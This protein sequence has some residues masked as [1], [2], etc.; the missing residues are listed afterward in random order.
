MSEVDEI[1]CICHES[2]S[3]GKQ[4]YKLPECDHNFHI[5]CISAWWIAPRDRNDE[6]GNCPLCRGVPLRGIWK[7]FT[8]A[9][10]ISQL[11]R[12]VKKNKV[13]KEVIKAL[14]KLQKA[15]NKLKN[16][17]QEW[18]EFAKR[19]DVKNICK[20]ITK[21]RNNRW[22]YSQQVHKYKLELAAF[23]PMA[24]INLI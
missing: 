2:L 12:L 14:H 4:T 19:P 17:R 13:P 11:K 15:E 10:R 6:P 18:R 24:F 1:C 8:V 20:Q 22:K 5:A 9:G 16:Q 3:N 7:R 21:N 23:D